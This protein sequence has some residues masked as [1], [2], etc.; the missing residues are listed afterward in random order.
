MSEIDY[1]TNKI[2]CID[3]FCGVGGLTRGLLDSGIDV[4]AGYDID[5]ECKFPYEAN[6]PG[7][8]FSQ[9][10][11]SKLDSSEV[12]DLF[13]DAEIRLLAG[14]A[15]CQPFS[16]YSRRYRKKVESVQ[17]EQLK[18][19]SRW[20][21][22][23]HFER[24]VR[25]IRPELVTMENVPSLKDQDVF[26]SFVASLRDLGYEVWF[27]IVDCAAFG[28][29]QKRNRLVLTAST[30]G[31]VPILRPAEIQQVTVYEAIGSLEKISAGQVS[32]SDP[33][34]VA[35]KL[36]PLNLKRIK[37]SRPGGTWKDWPQDLIADCHKRKSGKTYGGV[38]G[39]MSWA[40]PAPT[41][42]TQCYG[43]GNGR[44]GHPSQDRA[45]SLREAAILQGFNPDYKFVDDSKL[46]N[47][48]TLGRLIGNAVPV[49]LGQ[50]IGGRIIA[51]VRSTIS[52]PI[53]DSL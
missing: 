9:K 16:T 42:T 22:L 44:F 17:G 49:K 18:E 39:R 2:K 50:V 30:L 52:P 11:V 3:L 45:I 51:T 1:T 24:L 29:P 15:P 7:V 21:L 8:K 46:V 34:H 33:M 26:Q 35:S 4:I 38:Y 41:L 47:I 36:S 53:V 40:E 27:G 14:C 28:L 19:D 13:G 20:Y 31:K 12:E 25:E 43:F 48:K 37:A 6:N 32:T 5:P 10:D 23:N